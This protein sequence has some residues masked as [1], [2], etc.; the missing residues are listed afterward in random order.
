[1]KK[2]I[3]DIIEYGTNNT[4]TSKCNAITFINTGTTNAYINKFL[5][6][7]NASLSIQGNENEI[8]VTTYQLAFTGGT[9][10]L[11]VIRKYYQP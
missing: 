8:D 5:I 10:I 9:G 7:P 1:M 2:Y 6:A 3:V 4:L 11:T